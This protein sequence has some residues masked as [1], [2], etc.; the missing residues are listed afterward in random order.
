MMRGSLL[1]LGLFCATSLAACSGDGSGGANF[2]IQS[3]SLGC[4]TSGDQVNCGI[5][6][7]AVNQ[8]IR[9]RFNRPIALG[10]VNNNTF[11]VVEAGSGKTPLSTFRIDPND[12]A[13]LIYAPQLS[14]DSSGNPIFGLTAGQTYTFKLPGNRLDPSPFLEDTSSNPLETRMQCTLVASQGILDP[15][16]GA[17]RVTITILV[18]NPTTM[19][20]EPDVLPQGPFDAFKDTEIT[21]VFD[22]IINPGTLLNPVSGTSTFI[23]VKIDPDGDTSNPSDQSDIPGRFSLVIDSNALQTTA[24][25]TPTASLPSKGSGNPRKIV[26]TLASTIADLGG[27][28]LQNAGQ[29]IIIPEFVAFPPIVITEDYDDSSGEDGVHTGNVWSSGGRLLPGPAGGSG[30]LGDLDI[31]ANTVVTLSTVSED[32]TSITSP[33]IYDPG[34]IVDPTVFGMAE[35]VVN[36]TF[37]FASLRVRNGGTLRFSGPNP[38]RIFVRGEVVIEGDV[39]L[40]GGSAPAHDS[41]LQFG[42]VGGLA[43]SGG[44]DGGDGGDRPDGE[45][46]GGVNVTPDPMLY[47]DVDGKPGVGIP[48]PTTMNPMSLLLFGEGGIAWPQPTG[49][50][51]PDTGMPFHFPTS[52]L[53]ISGMQFD[54]ASVPN[55]CVNVFPGGAGAGGG[56]GLSGFP[57]IP[58]D[59]RNP[60]N[61]PPSQ[62]GPTYVL[63]PNTVGGDHNDLLMGGITD[64]QLRTLDP[65]TGLLRGG[66]GGGGGGAHLQLS[67]TNGTGLFL[68]RCHTDFFGVPFALMVFGQHSSAAGGGG[69]GGVQLQAG[70]DVVLT[71]IVNASGGDGG[72][73]TSA[74]RAQAGGG[75]AGGGVLMQSRQVVIQAV[76]G[77]IDFSGGLS[78]VGPTGSVGGAGGT[79][80]LRVETDLANLPSPLFLSQFTVPTGTDLA[81]MGVSVTDVLT[82]A[83]WTPPASGPSA[84][85]GAQS[86]W[87][88]PEGNFFLLD[89]Q[90]DIVQSLGWDMT[91]VFSGIPNPLQS[92]RGPNDIFPNDIQTTFG[93]ALDPT[94]DPSGLT[95][96]APV[97]V[98][99]QGARALAPLNDPCD[100]QLHGPTSEIVQGSLTGWVK[101]PEEL[102]TFYADPSLKPNMIR[103]CIIWDASKPA[104]SSLVGI[105]DL[106][107]RVQ[108]D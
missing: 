85:S 14:F 10:T 31:P 98:R 48:V 59:D 100:V 74:T 89:F 58:R 18:V 8:E 12:K 101:H 67:Q 6:D 29:S 79:G 90:S 87:I 61:I 44:G 80:Y 68:G 52:I 46:V 93:T 64:A 28:K 63:P 21:M 94:G 1:P 103:Y 108:P 57:G 23:T 49:M 91:L 19:Q 40:S 60:N 66:G 102:N 105:E 50:N 45:N 33:E 34:L 25:F 81:N 99:F 106:V 78:G 54:L 72:S 7:V 76:P 5:T 2:I 107:I 95:P 75:G 36:G 56:H 77:R 51:N 70:R 55:K 13:T 4:S 97:V 27:N 65:E 35:T 42:G 82:T 22:D 43:G 24:I 32:F 38:A 47:A 11:Q 9:I 62:G 69:G 39:D 84:L 41:T 86:C 92:Y 26:L 37:D 96:G 16:P 20:T 88:R 15:K 83:V 17:P 30:R 3:C 71:G 104:F 73:S 53:D